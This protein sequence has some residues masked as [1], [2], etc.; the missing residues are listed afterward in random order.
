MYSLGCH[1][2]I[3]NHWATGLRMKINDHSWS[4]L[5]ATL[6]CCRSFGQ[7]WDDVEALRGMVNGFSRMVLPLTKC[8]GDC[9]ISWRC[10]I[11]WAP[12][13]PD[14]NPPDFYLCGYLKDN[15]YE[16]NPQIILE[17]KKAITGRIKRISV[18]ELFRLLTKTFQPWRV[19][20]REI[21][22]V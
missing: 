15:V 10:E 12:Y 1:N 3:W 4:T 11:E 2:K 21:H 17:L 8:F 20:Y 22:L 18:E 14:L 7:H 13:S 5:S 6:K 16:N 19:W 9:P